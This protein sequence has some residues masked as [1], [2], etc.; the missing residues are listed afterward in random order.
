MSN[1]EKRTDGQMN[2]QKKPIHDPNKELDE[3]VGRVYRHYGPDLSNFIRDVQKDIQK[4]AA[5]GCGAP[6]RLSV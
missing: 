6:M 2:E 3:A 5:D 1:E 4:R